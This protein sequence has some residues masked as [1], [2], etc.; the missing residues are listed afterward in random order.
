MAA[1]S[2]KALR[3]ERGLTVEALAIM[4]GI[5]PATVSRVER[6]LM[7]PRPETIVKLARGLGIGAV[8]MERILTRGASH[9]RPPAA[10]RSARPAER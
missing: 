7:R 3:A 9:E 10:G 8:R 1:D 4:A 2:L 6:G 5:D